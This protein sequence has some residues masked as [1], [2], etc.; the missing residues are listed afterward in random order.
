[1]SERSRRGQMS[2]PLTPK[3]RRLEM[4]E[5]QYRREYMKYTL[6]RKTHNRVVDLEARGERRLMKCN[7]MAYTIDRNRRKDYGRFWE[8]RTNTVDLAGKVNHGK[9]KVATVAAA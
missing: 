5:E 2:L 7:L 4:W 6:T 1:M 9:L 3:M 8:L